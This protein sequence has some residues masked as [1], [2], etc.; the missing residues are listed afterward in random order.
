MEPRTETHYDAL[1]LGPEA[2][3]DEIRHA[4][5]R[6]AQQHHPDRAEGQEDN[7]DAMARIN[8]AYEVLSDPHQRAEY[9]FNRRRAALREARDHLPNARY[10]N[11]RP[12][13]IAGGLVTLGLV[14][15][16]GWFAFRTVPPP[17]ALPV[18]AAKP[19][20]AEAVKPVAVETAKSTPPP[21]AGGGPDDPLPLIPARSIGS[22]QLRP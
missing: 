12:W 6:L 10:L 18:E 16:A 1:Q 17:A 13:V 5:R 22:V 21:A 4:Y 8:R 3:F 14:A 15:G 19:A 11:A 7:G 20:P 9:D 2:S